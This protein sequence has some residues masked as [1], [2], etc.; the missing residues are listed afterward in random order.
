MA[1]RSNQL[2]V[3]LICLVLALAVW[4]VY[5]PVIWFDFTNYDDPDYVLEN[6][7][8]LNGLT[9]E[10]VRWAFTHFHSGNWHPLTWLSH[11][12]DC[13]V[14]EVMPTG[15]HVTNVIFHTL[16]TL[17]LFGLLRFLTGAPWRSAAVAAL[18]AV[19]P[20]HVESVA[21]ISER[22]TNVRRG[23]RPAVSSKAASV[24]PRG[25]RQV[26]THA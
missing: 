11:M 1:F 18:F 24:T 21:W 12:L 20:L 16:N 9:W 3:G 23:V 6:L 22:K 2:R 25:A 7:P 5:L 10:G 19:H 13:Q 8:V 14:Y 4:A 26:T 15:H 17:L